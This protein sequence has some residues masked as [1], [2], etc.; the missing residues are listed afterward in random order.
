MVSI[1]AGVTTAMT[2]YDANYLWEDILE[3][4]DCDDLVCLQE[5]CLTKLK[6][7]KNEK[8]IVSQS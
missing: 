1:G 4:S 6:F 2:L 7:M 5:F 3:V 8:K